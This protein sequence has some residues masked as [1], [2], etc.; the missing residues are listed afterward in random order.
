MNIDA[1]IK[2]ARKAIEKVESKLHSARV[3]LVDDEADISELSGLVIILNSTTS[4]LPRIS[5]QT[6][7]QEADS[8]ITENKG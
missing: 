8:D 2:R 3:H 5:T 4:K 6:K 1:I 7:S